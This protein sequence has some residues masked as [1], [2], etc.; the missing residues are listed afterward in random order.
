MNC[1]ACDQAAAWRIFAAYEDDTADPSVH[2]RMA[3]YPAPMAT[4]CDDHLLTVIQTDVR[5]F[6]STNCWAVMAVQ[7]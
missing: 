5:A 4:V 7:S 1:T 3:R 6:A 2:P